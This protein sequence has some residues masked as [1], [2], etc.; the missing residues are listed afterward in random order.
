MSVVTNLILTFSR[1]EDEIQRI[2]EVNFFRCDGESINLISADYLRKTNLFGIDNRK[3]WYG[4][5][6]FLEAP[7]FIGALNHF[8]LSDFIDHLNDLDWEDKDRVQLIIKQ[9]GDEKFKIIELI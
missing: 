8:N 1:N 4:G 9:E 2:K 6:K 7:L 5:T 3:N